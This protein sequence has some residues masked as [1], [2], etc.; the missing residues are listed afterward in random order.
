MKACFFLQRRFAFIGHNLAL[1]LKEKY[2]M[3]NFCGFV[4]QRS[5]YDFLK[6]QKDIQYTNLLLDEDIHKKFKNEK[7]DLDYLHWLE[8]EYGIPNLW[9]YLIADRIIMH[10]QLVREYPYDKAPFTHEEMLRILQVT[11]KEIILFLE[12]E[13]PDVIIFSIVSNLGSSL[14][15]HI[16]K[17]IGIKTLVLLINIAKHKTVISENFDKFSGADEAYKKW[18]TEIKKNNTPPEVKNFLEQ[19]NKR[20]KSYYAKG[21]PLNQQTNRSRQFKFLLPWNFINSLKWLLTS[22]YRHINSNER[23]DFSYI[24]P[25]NSLR[26]S[27]KRKARNIFGFDELYDKINLE[28]NFVFFPLQSEPECSLLVLAQFKNNQLEAIK[29]VSYSLP[30]GYKLYVKEHPQMVMY[31][32]RS[33]YKEIKKIPGV[34]LVDP[35]TISY[36]LIKKARV[37]TTITGT[38]GWEAVLLKKPVIT[39]GS[40]FYNQLSFVK[41]CRAY[42]DLPFL[43]KEQI[44]NFKYDEDE[45]LAF[46]ATLFENSATNVD[47]NYLWEEETDWKKQKKAL[48]PLADLIAKKINL[49]KN[50]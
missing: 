48:E 16:A 30:V 12:K 7:L 36:E 2:D 20:P 11:A 35:Q 15:Y 46:L 18:L 28:E 47:I 8:K 44:D 26:D 37:I 5:S 40:I 25:W 27:L 39:F 4:S 3:T 32:L 6:S 21:N 24:K 14:L 19:F 45:L 10:N 34:K 49:Q 1:N 43:V 13:K 29:Q 41:K 42:E 9:P 38:V 17:K 33:Y 50:A 31:R 23:S 22:F